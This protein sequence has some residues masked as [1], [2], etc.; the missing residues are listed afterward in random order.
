MLAYLSEKTE[1]DVLNSIL[2]THQSIW[3]DR[4]ETWDNMTP[5]EKVALTVEGMRG[6]LSGESRKGDL[7]VREEPDRF[8]ISFDPCGTG[9]VMRR[10]D[11]ETGR[12]AYAPA[13]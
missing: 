5:W 8:A 9:G 4:Y 3:G 1:E 13:M 2:E 10:G 7:I 12:S 6:H 11:P